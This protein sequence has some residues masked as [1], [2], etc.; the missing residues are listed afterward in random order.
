LRVGG[1]DERREQFLDDAPTGI[2]AEVL[3]DRCRVAGKR[4]DER[5]ES[6]KP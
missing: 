4:Q 5:A 6:A 1:L 3:A 2:V